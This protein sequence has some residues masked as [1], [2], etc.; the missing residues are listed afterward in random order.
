ME[1]ALSGV[2]TE[3]PRGSN[4]FGYDPVFLPYGSGQT[5]AEMAPALKNTL[6]HRAKAVEKIKGKL[7][8]YFSGM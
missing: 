3:S 1:G 6:S 5:L 8:E 2:I 4:G 7:Q